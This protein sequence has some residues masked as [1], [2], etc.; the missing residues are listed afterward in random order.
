[1]G[2]LGHLLLEH[3]VGLH[4]APAELQ[5]VVHQHAPVLRA[6]HHQQPLVPEPRQVRPRPEAGPRLARAQDSLRL[7]CGHW[8][9]RT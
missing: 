4:Q 2:Q 6:V 7:E 1:M 9:E 3:D 8:T 5:C